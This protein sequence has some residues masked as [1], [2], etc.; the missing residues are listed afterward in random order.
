MHLFPL[1][2][3]DS[4]KNNF[5]GAV[6]AAR[7]HKLLIIFFSLYILIT[8]GFDIVWQHRHDKSR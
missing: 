4:Q 3:I 2:L 7:A 8:T 6:L 1:L 5:K